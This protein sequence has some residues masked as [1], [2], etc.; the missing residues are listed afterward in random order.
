M[1]LTQCIITIYSDC[2]KSGDC[3]RARQKQGKGGEVRARHAQLGNRLTGDGN[4][5]MGD[6]V[7]HR[8]WRF[9]HYFTKVRCTYLEL[10]N[11][12]CKINTLR[13]DHLPPFASNSACR[14]WGRK[15]PANYAAKRT[16]RR[17]GAIIKRRWNDGGTTIDPRLLAP[18]LRSVMDR[19][20][21][22]NM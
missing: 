14:T 6:L 21:T 1:T 15:R 20:F 2:G 7:D 5:I 16:R 13:F 8:R 17:E 22:L 19:S 3:R 18:R 9:L 11:C 12:P 10:E 4:V